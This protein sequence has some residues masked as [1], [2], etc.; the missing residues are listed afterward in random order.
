MKA[1]GVEVAYDVY[2]DEAAATRSAVIRDNSG[3]LVQLFESRAR[4]SSK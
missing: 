1:K 2:V 4:E 3:N